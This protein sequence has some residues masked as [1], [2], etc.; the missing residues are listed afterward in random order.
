[1]PTP[2]PIKL[3]DVVTGIELNEEEVKHSV[4]I[5]KEFHSQ[6]ASPQRIGLYGEDLE[7]A[8]RANDSV[9]IEYDGRVGERVFAPI[10]VPA[11]HLYWFNMDLLRR[12]YGDTKEFL[13]FT[14][15][16]IPEE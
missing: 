3:T 13:Y 1:M 16:P 11:E 10:L 2:V 8:L 9:L 4:E 14:H 12:T 5:Y 7:K 6:T 15:P